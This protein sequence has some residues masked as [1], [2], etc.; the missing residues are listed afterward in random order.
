M[1]R[2]LTLRA[3]APAPLH[4]EP[5]GRRSIKLKTIGLVVALTM[6]GA[7]AIAED[8]TGR[9]AAQVETSTP[10]SAIPREQPA[11]SAEGRALARSRQS[12]AAHGDGHRARPE[13]LSPRPPADGRDAPDPAVAHDGERWALFSTQVGLL[14]IP[15]ALSDDLRDWS[16]PVDALPELPPWVKWGHTWAP[17][18]LR[19]SDGFVLYFA[20]RHRA[21]GL[22]CIG[23]AIARTIE[24]PYT[25]PGRDP[26]VCQSHL[27]GSIDPQ[28]FVDHDGATYLL[29]KADSN[30]IGQTSQLFAQ[31]LRPDGLAL[32]GEAM[33]LLHND[34]AWESPLIE[35]P[36]LVAAH[37][38]YLLFY[39][40]GWY[41]SAG[42]AVGYAVCDTPL[43]PCAKQTTDRPLLA[44]AGAEAGTG[45]ATVLTGPAGD[46]WLAYHAWTPGAI[47]YDHGGA[48]SVRFASI[49]WNGDQVAVAR[50][51]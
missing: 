40:G 30:A 33:P 27:G 24:G 41:N 14:N 32:T 36:A 29:W 16:R 31:R 48:R 28:P 45:G 15:V 11:A 20:A 12:D 38:T 2:T 42:Y 34:A 39:S 46:V 13:A 4:G 47:G 18:V 1:A 19:R 51:Q 49:T 43:G 3:Q 5:L 35:N 25:S 50:R 22:Q 21:L 8:A 6:G 7:S 23:V 17:G 10:A 9:H 44:S 37:G 26:L